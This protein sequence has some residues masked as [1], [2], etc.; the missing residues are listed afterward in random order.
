MV[1]DS[2]LI[3]G[4]VDPYL[5]AGSQNR[6]VFIPTGSQYWCDTFVA[7]TPLKPEADEVADSAK[8]FFRTSSGT[9]STLGEWAAYNDANYPGA[10]T[11]AATYEHVHG[12]LA[13]SIRADSAAKKMAF[14][15]RFYTGLRNQMNGYYLPGASAD[16]P[17]GN[18]VARVGQGA[19]STLPSTGQGGLTA[20]WNSGVAM[21]WASGYYMTAWKQPWRMTAFYQSAQGGGNTTYAAAKSMVS[22]EYLPRFNVSL[23]MLP[24]F[25][26][27]VL[28]A[29]MQVGN[30][31]FGYGA[32]R[33]NTTASFENELVWYLD[34]LEEFKFT[35]ANYGAYIN[36]VV[37]MRPT[38]DEDG[39]LAGGAGK[40]PN[41]QLSVV[42][43]GLAFYYANIKNDSRIPTWMQTLADFI[44]GQSVDETT[45]YSM[46][47]QQDANPT[48][49]ARESYYLSFFSELFGWVYAYTGNA[50]YKT[51]ALRAAN[52]REL[53]QPSPFITNVKAYGEYFGGHLQSAKFYIDGGSIR[54]IAGAHPTAIVNPPTYTS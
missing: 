5:R 18:V 27:Y 29:T 49:V 12:F 26:G 7:L 45:H 8:T 53:R 48:G 38:A 40:F 4:V 31:D 22:P 15:E 37:G 3:S 46:P 33:N 36:G 43:R 16:T 2:T 23:R 47:Y 32:G 20:E 44:I 10:G 35:T 50:T 11:G 51:W 54:H 6:A 14:Y 28:D 52:E 9:A 21:G 34:A 13:S 25:T 41:F 1:Y 19:D 17:N 24:C 30:G 42:A 39:G